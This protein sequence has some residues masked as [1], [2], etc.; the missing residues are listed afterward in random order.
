MGNALTSETAQIIISVIPIVGIGI[1]GIVVFFY[2][3]WHH[4][5]VKL[6]I[7]NG[8]YKTR[9]FD[10]ETFSLLT[11]L[12]LT[13]IGFILTVLFL[14]IEGVSYVL[15]GGLIPFIIGVSLLIFFKVNPAFKVKNDKY[16][17]K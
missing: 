8:T 15:L 9:S 11:G 12:L 3:L 7:I 10:L 14:C 4:H 17:E 6:R 13:G 16:S 5:E 2:I 1:G